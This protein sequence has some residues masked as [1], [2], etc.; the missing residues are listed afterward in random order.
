MQKSV[1][2]L[3]SLI[4]A[5]TLILLF[6]PGQNTLL[7]PAPAQASL[8]QT[9]EAY[10]DDTLAL[11]SVSLDPQ[12]WSYLIS[13]LTAG[14]GEPNQ[15]Q[16]L[17][18]E[19]NQ[20]IEF[21]Q[22]DLQ[23]DPLRDGLLNLGSH[24]TMAYRPYG[25]SN[26]HL[27]FSLNLRSPENVQKLL[28]RLK[29][30][31]AGQ[32]DSRGFKAEN[33]GGKEMY[34]LE[35]A[36]PES[37]ADD[38]LGFN[39][40]SLA[41]SGPNLIGTL[42][43]GPD[44]L[45][46]MLY[47]QAVLPATSR[48]KLNQQALFAPVRDSLK[49]KA[50][51]FY[52]DTK[53]AVKAANLTQENAMA[54]QNL[55]AASFFA[56]ADQVS[57][58]TGGMGVGFDIDREG[59]KLK[60]FVGPDRPNLT[61]RQQEYL[62]AVQQ[63]PQHGLDGLLAAKPGEPLLMSAGQHLDV[64]LSKPMPVDV[65]LEAKALL[66]DTEWVRKLTRTLL[67]VDYQ[68]EFLPVI[69]GR[70]GF[71]IFEPAQ[72]QGL[73][74][75]VLYLGLKDGQE[76]T[77]DQLMQKKFRIRPETLDTLFQAPAEPPTVRANLHTLS[78]VVETFGADWGGVYPANLAHLQK[79]AQVAGR[80]YWKDLTNP[81][82]GES[83]PEQSLGDYSSFKPEPAFAGRVFYQ[84]AG[85]QIV[86]ESGTF[87]SAYELYGY[88]PA[89]LL[90]R[91]KG[92]WNQEGMLQTVR[93][94]LP[95]V[96]IKAPLDPDQ[97]PDTAT[98]I[99]PRELESWQD[100]PIYTLPVMDPVRGLVKEMLGQD[101]KP[102][103]IKGN[104]YKLHIMAQTFGVDWGG[105][106]PANLA[107]LE[108]EAQAVGREYWQEI[109]NLV[110]GESGVGQAIA[111]YSS[112]RADAAMAGRVFYQP[113][114]E[115]LTYEGDTFYTSYLIYGYDADGTLYSIDQDSDYA[116]VRQDLPKVASPAA[117]E[118]EP[119]RPEELL[120]GIQP[121]FARKGNVW[122]LALHPDTL[123]AALGGGKPAKIEHWMKLTGSE[124]ARALFFWDLQSTTA[125]IK[126]LLPQDALDSEEAQTLSRALEPWHS[127]F[128]ASRQLSTGTEGHLAVN[129]DLDKVDFS[130]IGSAFAGVVENFQGAERRA[131]ISS[132]KANMHMLQTTVETYAVDFGGIYPASVAEMVKEAKAREYWKEFA[133]P[134][135]GDF[136]AFTDLDQVL[137]DFENYQP[138]K[139]MAGKLLYQPIKAESGAIT[140]YKIFGVDQAGNLIQDKGQ[141]FYLTNL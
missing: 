86:N 120:D 30:K 105:M 102:A 14:E 22:K 27:L 121:V 7:N 116:T 132:V 126:R 95:K 81:V 97:L 9:L 6:Q 38:M 107:R 68:T 51:W 129:A 20:F 8:E 72:A 39:Q 35:L 11:V 31:M 21:M 56:F 73:P 74:Q 12:H 119:S 122:M 139:E 10:P 46:R 37:P 104:M 61:P 117:S 88:D 99:I 54:E 133:N 128:A 16:Q 83:S 134:F 75:L 96:G 13:R 90:Y 93:E 71:G 49:D 40:L 59:L 125:V 15:G 36:N 79:E 137:I 67:N 82:S 58:L 4:L 109:G 33:F 60:S 1:R 91:I 131:K 140:S 135:T 48:F 63:Q 32:E 57:N 52:L 23:F 118:A 65:P 42:G 115:P 123:K 19:F 24:L 111:D 17:P 53:G 55:E 100:T 113:T 62:A 2:R 34:S 141:D 101:Q 3:K 114:G 41:V 70:Y 136:S 29:A 45:K 87:Y 64:L 94:D 25:G 112:F 18:G 127:I 98:T 28:K 110:T 84:P 77:F 50:L 108:K 130:Q 5:T 47:M 78:I 103:G 26:G 106:Y 138:G 89:G 92:A 80:E 124:D 76:A 66:P 85:Q 43:P 44:L 69:D